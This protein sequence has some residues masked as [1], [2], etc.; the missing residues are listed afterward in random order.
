MQTV[1]APFAYYGGKKKIA[2]WILQFVPEHCIYHEAFA[3]GAG[4]FWAKGRPRVGNGDAYREVLNDTSGAIVDVFRAL[5]DEH[6]DVLRLMQLIPYGEA[7]YR[8]SADVFSG[9][10]KPRT[11]AE[12]AAWLL[13]YWSCS[14]AGK[15][16]GGLK[17]ARTSE[18]PAAT[19]A[20]KSALVHSWASRLSGVYIEQTDYRESLAR[21]DSPGTLHYCDPPYVGANQ[22]H[23]SGWTDEDRRDL[24]V[25]V[26]RLEGA[27]IVSGYL[28]S[29]CLTFAEDRRWKVEQ[30]TV[31]V[32]A[33]REKA[34]RVEWIVVKPRTSDLGSAQARYLARRDLS[35]VNWSAM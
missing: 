8:A 12:R 23:Y 2:K 11:V 29:W 6:E 26:D 19:W 35:G 22:G 18:N 32:S 33:G 5:R 27:A 24:F 28:D 16:G 21:W 25:A 14:F 15:G 7:S 10:R 31:G 4:L 17:R 9:R 20:N 34:K 30:K 1:K 3:G 13:F